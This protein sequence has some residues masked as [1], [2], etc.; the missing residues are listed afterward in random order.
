LDCNSWWK[1]KIKGESQ[2][3]DSPAGLVPAA[4]VEPV[5]PL[6]PIYLSNLNSLNQ[7]G[8]TSVV[9]AMY[10]YEANA[11]GELSVKEDELLLVFD[12]EEDWLLVQSQK[13]GGKAGFVPGN[14]VEVILLAFSSLWNGLNID[15]QP[16]R[17]KPSL[18]QLP[19]S[20]FRLPYAF[21]VWLIN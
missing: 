13:E 5:S 6:L 4:Y 11:P 8:H 9:K 10:D 19:K 12:T 17:K 2:E 15:R 21:I 18:N 20:S 7:A 14:Y 3:E 16:A 1:V